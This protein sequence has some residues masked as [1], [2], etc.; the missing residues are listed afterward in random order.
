MLLE[1]A[2][3]LD[4]EDARELLGEFR[5]AIELTAA[6]LREQ[7]SPYRHLLDALSAALGPA[8]DGDVAELLRLASEGPPTEEVGLEPFAPPE[9][10]PAAAGA[11]R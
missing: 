11:G 8:A 1:L 2:D 9:V 5:A 3:M 10:M 7:S 4:P 6:A